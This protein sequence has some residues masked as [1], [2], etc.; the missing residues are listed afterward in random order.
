MGAGVDPGAFLLQSRVIIVTGKGGTGKTTLS[1]TLAN[2]AARAGLRAAV[3]Q[4]GERST[5]SNDPAGGEAPVPSQLARL[6]GQEKTIGWEPTV[7][8][9]SPN[10]GKVE[11]R[12]LRP[13]VALVE[14][15]HL[16]GMRRLS[17]RL[18]A[19]GALDVVATAIP[20]MPDLLILGKLK[21]MERA[22]AT[23]QPDAPDLIILDAPAAGHAVRFLQSPHGLL[24]AVTGGPVHAQ[25][26]DVVKMLSDPRRCQVM[27][28]TLPEETPVSET[29]ETAYL[30]ED[31]VGVHL[32]PVIV[33]G[34]LPQLLLP[35][36]LDPQT[37]GPLA[38]DNGLELGEEEL[39]SLCA[40]G[41][42]RARRQAAQAEQVTRL[43]KVLPLPQLQ[44]PFCF[45]AALGPD[46]LAVLTDALAQG[47]SALSPVAT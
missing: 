36:Q 42:L 23:G 19:S 45:S 29:I 9:S 4:I 38:T 30:I 8:L 17:R 5:A 10:G 34:R 13:D 3:V 47:I 35:D 14:Y 31:S 1:G 27:I 24:E 20:G 6:F 32:A 41:L 26:E 44:L 7:L 46:E 39:A 33:N 2:L 28:V 18:V 25:A 21:Q 16:H 40:A 37:L 22:A 12:D 15:L 43:A 11:A